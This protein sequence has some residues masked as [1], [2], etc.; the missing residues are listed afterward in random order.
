LDTSIGHPRYRK[1]DPCDSKIL[2]MVD[3][4]KLTLD[5][6]LRVIVHRDDTTPLVA[7]NILY[8]VGSRDE[9]PERTGFAHLFEHLMFGGSQHIPSYDTPLQLVGGENNAF[10]STDIT[11]YYLTLPSQNLETAFWLESDRMLSL[12]FSENSLEVQRNVVI[13]EFKQRYLNQPYGDAW[14]LLR[15][16]AYQHHPYR[17]PTIGREI[18]HIEEARLEEVKLFFFSH[19]APNNAILVLAG[20]IE[21]EDGVRLAEKWFGPIERREIGKRTLPIEPMQESHRFMEVK[22]DVPYPAIYKAWH[23]PARRDHGYHACD[24][25]TDILAG[26]K[27]SRLYESLVKQKKLFGDID[28]YLTGEIDPGL[29]VVSGRLMRGISPKQGDHAIGEE[30]MKLVEEE[31]DNEELTKVKNKIESSLTYS[32][33]NVLSRAMNMAFFELIDQAEAIN[34]EMD[35]YLCIDSHSLKD[36]ARKIFHPGNCSTLFYLPKK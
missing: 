17:W 13:E 8:D 26:G 3:L 2:I 6:G 33:S 25:I 21:Y 27:S 29:L 1:D 36:E 18:R 19:Y 34:T 30:M 12:D 28:A 5:N 9:D 4:K 35:K 11:N 22:R 7:M 20:N 31:I 24:L 15:P 16:L 14:L 32:E 10:T 23:V